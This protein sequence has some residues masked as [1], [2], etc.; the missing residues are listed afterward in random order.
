MKHSDVPTALDL[1]V[2]EVGKESQRIRDAGGEALK[3]G[4]LSPAKK[5]FLMLKR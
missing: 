1:V 2:E 4:K 5:R 3:A